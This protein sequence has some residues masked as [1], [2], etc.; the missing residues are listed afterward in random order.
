MQSFE[1]LNN[2][3]LVQELYK[4]PSIPITLAISKKFLSCYLQV[5][6]KFFIT[7]ENIRLQSCNPPEDF[8]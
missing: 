5:E 3:G 1:F 6:F 2:C 7:F 8:L 4:L